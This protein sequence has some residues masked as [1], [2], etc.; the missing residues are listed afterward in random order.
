M[1]EFWE[2]A[3]AERQLIWGIEPTA[4]AIFATDYFARMGVKDVLVPGVGY[5]TSPSLHSVLI[6]LAARL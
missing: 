2:T 4:S 5:R 1:R 3:F 6:R